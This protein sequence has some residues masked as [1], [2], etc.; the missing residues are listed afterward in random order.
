MKRKNRLRWL[1]L[2]CAAVSLILGL[3]LCRLAAVTVAEDGAQNVESFRVPNGSPVIVPV[4]VLGETRLFL[5]DTGAGICLLDSRFGSRL[6]TTG[7]IKTRT[8]AG[9]VMLPTCDQPELVIGSAQ[10]PADGQSVL[11]DMTPFCEATG[12]NLYGILGVSALR[13][14]VIRFIPHDERLDILNSLPVDAGI[15]IPVTWRKTGTMELEMVCSDSHRE[16]FL[17]DTGSTSEVT[18]RADLFDFLHGV[19]SIT[20]LREN[21]VVTANGTVQVQEGIMDRSCLGDWEH[22]NVVVIRGTTFSYVGLKYLNRYTVTFDFPGR[23]L[24][25]KPGK[26]FAEKSRRTCLGTGGLWREGKL[27]LK[28]VLPDSPAANAG[29]KVGDIIESVNGKPVDGSSLFKLRRLFENDG[30]TVSLTLRRG[31]RVATVKIKLADF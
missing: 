29:L 25:L 2:L 16:K 21:A 12:R 3:G 18:L 27:R 11:F 8:A 19:G 17:V 24:F 26:Y 13:D 28:Y 15:E 10:V 22:S 5:F 7:N 1:Q 6:K 14:Y 30:E 9:T 4:R 23:R 31:D 20:R